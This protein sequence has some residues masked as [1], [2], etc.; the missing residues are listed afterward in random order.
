MKYKPIETRLLLHPDLSRQQG[1]ITLWVEIFDKKDMIHM[2]PWQIS[3]EPK[4]QIEMRLTVWETENM[5]LRDDE[6]TSDV[7]ITCFFDPKQKQSTDVHYRCQNGTASFNWRMVYQLDL[8]SIYKT[9]VIQAYD[10]GIFSKD[11]FITRA[12]LEIIRMIKITK[13]LDVP[14]VFNKDY[15]NDVPDFE[16][17]KYKSVEFLDKLNDPD[18]TKFWIQCYRNSTK[19][20]RILM[21]LEFMPIWKAEKSPVGKGRS[22]PN[23]NPYLPP[24][25]GRFEWSFNPFKL[26]RQC[27]GPKV[28]RKLY[29]T[30][31]IICCAIYLVL[32]LPYMIYHLSGQLFNPFNY[33]K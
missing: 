12:E 15:V 10:K 4:T 19:S 21:S 13:D 1:N 24:P 20:G 23:V 6:G 18:Q 32:L 7:F 33:M 3:P 11:D 16:K 22:D 25:V 30:I 9:L 29:M 2:E 31:C 27:V 14:I 17:D 26:L 8:P 28:R 5:E